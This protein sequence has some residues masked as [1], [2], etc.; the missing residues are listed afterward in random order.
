MRRSVFVKRKKAV[1]IR[2]FVLLVLFLLIKF[3]SLD[4]SAHEVSDANKYYT[5]VLVMPGETLT[6]I[7]G[8]YMSSEFNSINDYIDEVRQ[9]NYLSYDCKIHTG[10]YI[11]VPYY[12]NEFY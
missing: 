6:D 11:V 7:A 1:L 9:M 10:E 8:R 2:C 5:S 3:F 12:S 4:V